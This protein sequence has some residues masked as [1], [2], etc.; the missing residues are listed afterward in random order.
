MLLRNE[1]GVGPAG[2][3]DFLA[4]FFRS[5]IEAIKRAVVFSRDVEKMRG[6]IDIDAPHPDSLIGPRFADNDTISQSR[7]SLIERIEQYAVI[8]TSGERE[9][10]SAIIEFN[11]E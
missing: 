10:L 4:E 3:V 2:Q 5:E 6:F 8:V 1:T 9:V 7:L 11:A